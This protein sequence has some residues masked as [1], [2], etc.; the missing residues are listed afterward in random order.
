MNTTQMVRVSNLL[1]FA[2]ISVV[3]VLYGPMIKELF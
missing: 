3:A 2:A 1:H